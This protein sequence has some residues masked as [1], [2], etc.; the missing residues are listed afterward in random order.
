MIKTIDGEKIVEVEYDG[1]WCSSGCGNDFD[2]PHEESWAE[3]L[4]EN[5][6]KFSYEKRK[7]VLNF[8]KDEGFED[9]LEDL[10]I[11]LCPIC[12][13][14]GEAWDANEGDVECSCIKSARLEKKGEDAFELARG[15]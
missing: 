6:D 4:V 15:N 14:T 3:L 8:L 5:F 12:L 11:T 2:C 13:G 9:I 7:E 1:R 10:K